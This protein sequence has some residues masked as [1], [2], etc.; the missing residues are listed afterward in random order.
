M[1]KDDLIEAANRPVTE[2]DL[3]EYRRWRREMEDEFE[4]TYY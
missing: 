4:R 3:I 1:T 2:E